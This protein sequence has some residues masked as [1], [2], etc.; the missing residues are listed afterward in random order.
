MSLRNGENVVVMG[1]NSI[2]SDGDVTYI[3]LP[4]GNAI[5]FTGLGVYTP[6]G[7]QTQRIGLSPDI[8]VKRTI[9]GVK[10]ERD[11]FMEA[12]IKYILEN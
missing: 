6:D 11:E 4:C 2:G 9:E 1:E 12:A 5:S 7:G 10:E 8:Y 3:P